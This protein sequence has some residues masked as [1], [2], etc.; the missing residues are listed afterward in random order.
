M[1]SREEAAYLRGERA[2]FTRMLNE[3]ARGLG[4][5]DPLAASTRAISEMEGT[6]AALRSTCA[7]HGDNEW[8]DD[9][10]LADVVEK[11][12]RRYIDDRLEAAVLAERERCAKI[13]ETKAARLRHVPEGNQ[14]SDELLSLAARIRSGED[15][16]A[17]ERDVVP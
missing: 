13:L 17:A 16:D 6:R 15:A 1:D 9:L 5:D 4:Y 8:D 10:H 11:H 2:A 3:A 12:L 7:D 14:P